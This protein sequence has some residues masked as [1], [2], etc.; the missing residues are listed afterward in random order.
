MNN[1]IEKEMW[2][3][4]AESPF[5]MLQL[6]NASEHAVPMTVQLDK[7]AD[8]AVWFY[9]TKDNRVAR[10]GPAMAQYVSRDHKLFCCIAGTL[11]E[12]TDPAALD[13]H[14][15][16]SVESWYDGGRNDPNLHIMRFELG[17]AEIWTHDP[18]FK[19]WFKLMT[20]QDVSPEEVGDHERLSLQSA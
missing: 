2:E 1:P 15:S 4:M 11:T 17:E 20:G 3:A 6:Q 9:T 8:G 13:R 14:W 18:G 12:E 19:G 10:G 5:L 7:D 16:N